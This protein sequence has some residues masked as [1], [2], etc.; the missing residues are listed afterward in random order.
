[1]SEVV[2]KH[3]FTT[4]KPDDATVDVSK[5]EW[6]DTHKI[7]ASGET[8]GDLIKRGTS[9][10]ERFPIGAV[11]QYL[12]S[13][14]TDP[15]WS[16]IL[17]GDLPSGIALNK[18]ATLT[19]NRA[20][21]SD[22]SGVISVS[23]V[24]ATELGHLAGVTSAIQTQLDGKAS[25]AHKDTH[26]TGGSDAF[27]VSDLLD[28]I[29]RTTVR[30]NSGSDVG[31]RRRINFVEGANVTITLADD[32]GNEE[33]DVTIEASG[34]GGGSVTLTHYIPLQIL[35]PQTTVGYPDIPKLVTA[36]AKTSGNVLPDGSSVSKINLKSMTPCP[37]ELATSPNARLVLEFMT[38][39]AVGGTPSIRITIKR[40][41]RDTGEDMDASFI[42]ETADT[43]DVS[44][45]IE[46]ST[47]FTKTLGAQPTAGE[48]LMFTVERDP[49]HADDDYTGDI[50]LVG[51][52]VMIER[53]V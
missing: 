15:V 53:T 1:M 51:A 46:H 11:G 19:A 13:D 22:G 26:K 12:R 2:A 23:S 34:G 36:D 39:A 3:R 41:Y 7:E 50:I 37:N 33:V 16:A 6:N 42:A 44:T 47:F 18:L 21:Q 45:S 49:T 10:W 31:S 20:L 27:T 40:S 28:A 43:I 52:Y 32:A 14:G 5:D 9:L 24:T 8:R 29:A 4:T 35:P 17:A 25:T 30:K 38:L 48:K